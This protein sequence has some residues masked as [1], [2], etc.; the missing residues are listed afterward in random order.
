MGMTITL[1]VIVAGVIAWNTLVVVPMRQAAV[2][3]R[4][5]RFLR[6]LVPGPHFLVPFLDRIAYRHEMREQVIDVPSQSCITRDNIQVDVDGIVYLRVIDPERASYGIEDYRRAAINLA[7]TTMRA[8]MGKLPLDQVFSERDRLNEAIVSEIDT[9]SDPWGVK[10]L[11]YE[12]RDITPTDHVVHTLEKQ[13]EAERQRRAEVTNAEAGR[14][15]MINVSEGER[16]AAINLSEGDKQRRINE[17][18]GRAEAISVVAAAT[19]SATR[20]V[21]E[22]IRAPGGNEAVKMK[23]V[24]QYLEGLARILGEAQVTVVPRELATVKGLADGVAQVIGAA[25]P[26]S[27]PPPSR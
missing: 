5:G 19:A 3:E 21:A 8:E 6:V 17:A 12:I 24:R 1:A 16:Q 20:R 27:H 10:I 4:L 2:V 18:R 22:A 13:M 15:A 7:Q 26:P 9:A 25:A 23:L 14:E 11:R